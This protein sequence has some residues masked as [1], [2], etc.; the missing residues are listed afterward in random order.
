M[1]DALSLIKIG[2]LTALILA[3]VALWLRLD[4]EQLRSQGLQEKLQIAA[5]ANT[6]ASAVIDGL[7]A[8]NAD[9]NKLLVERQQRY[10]KQE[11]RLHGDINALRSKLESVDCYSKPWPRTVSER[12]RESY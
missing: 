5:D 9:V 10:S 7:K 1:L 8:D 4:A 12:L 2:V 3:V 11:A 6:A